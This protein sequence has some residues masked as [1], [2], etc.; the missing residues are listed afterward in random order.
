MKFGSEKIRVLI[1]SFAL[2][3]S[4]V[5]FSAIP[6]TAAPQEVCVETGTVDESG[7]PNLKCT[8][9]FDQSETF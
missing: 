1:L 9:S 8:R 3:F 5:T 4:S 6:V 7:Q 2:I